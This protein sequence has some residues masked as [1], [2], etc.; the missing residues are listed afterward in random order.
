MKYFFRSSII[1]IKVIKFEKIKIMN[2]CI[3]YELVE[4]PLSC[5]HCVDGKYCDDC[6]DKIDS[7]TIKKC[8]ICRSDLNNILR[9]N[10]LNNKF[11]S[12][13]KR[14]IELEAV[15]SN[16]TSEINLLR[17]MESQFQNHIERL[18]SVIIEN[19]EEIEFLNNRQNYLL[20]NTIEEINIENINVRLNFDVSQASNTNSN[21]R[22]R[23]AMIRRINSHSETDRENF[24]NFIGRTLREKGHS[25]VYGCLD[26]I[27]TYNLCLAYTESEFSEIK[28]YFSS[29]ER[30][31]RF[32]KTKTR[33]NR[34]LHS[35]KIEC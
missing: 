3:C 25:F 32:R 6:F 28:S 22:Y 29:Y 1:S 27:H 13:K 20:R 8:A 19:N 12:F 34:N 16:L 26:G 23:N 33:T 4:N 14:I 7:S 30:V 21:N 31:M 10:L 24:K 15:N 18:I 35:V 17:T 11:N 2:C 5:S 9:H